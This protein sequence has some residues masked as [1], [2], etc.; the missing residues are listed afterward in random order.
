MWPLGDGA[1]GNK[2]R[3]SEWARFKLSKLLSLTPI[4][5]AALSP[6][7]TF[8]FSTMSQN[9]RSNTR[10]GRVSDREPTQ[11]EKH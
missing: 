5:R 10:Q 9:N 2:S 8:E 1:A 4:H 6:A 3:A 7:E 11:R